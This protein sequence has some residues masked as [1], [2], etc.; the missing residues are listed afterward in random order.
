VAE[1]VEA[2]RAWL[3]GLTEEPSW[4]QLPSPYIKIR[5]GIRIGREPGAEEPGVP[6]QLPEEVFYAQNGAL[7]LRQLTR[8]FESYNLS[9]LPSFVSAFANWT[10]CANGAGH[11]RNAN[12]DDRPSEWNDIFIRL[13]ANTL[14]GLGFEQASTAVT[15]MI[16]VPDSSFFELAADLVRALDELHFNDRGLKLETATQLRSM[17]AERLTKTSGWRRQRDRSELSIETRIGP[18]IAALFF[19]HYNGFSGT[20]CYLLEKGVQQVEPFLPVL[21]H[22]I[23]EGPV[24]FT[25]LLTMNLLEV[26]RNPE[27]VGFF[28][29]SALTWL[30]REPNNAPLWIE[31]GVGARLALWIETV[32]G[33]DAALRASTHP[34]RA[35]IDDLLARLV[36]AGVAEAYRIEQSLA[37]VS[38]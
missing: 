38:S 9:W 34:L 23:D 16:A 31:M 35:Q 29:S 5:R 22:L 33:I 28:L 20:R 30:R 8:G 17:I 7:W 21:S 15:R 2:E 25:A 1:A 32:A 37:R 6:A 10:T 14:S 4:P 3:S 13:F 26:S 12:V 18:A 19:N 24:P 27:H 11:D 36:Q